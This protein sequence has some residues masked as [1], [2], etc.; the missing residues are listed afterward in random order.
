[1]D[2]LPGPVRAMGLQNAQMQRDMAAQQAAHDALQAR[3]TD[4]ESAV[5]A[6]KA[7][8]RHRRDLR[9]TLGSTLCAS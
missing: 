9:K 5:Q 7:D 1:M 6:L 3:V 4:L 2:A 8:M